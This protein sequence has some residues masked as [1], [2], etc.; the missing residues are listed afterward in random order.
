MP[1]DYS[2]PRRAPLSITQ[3]VIGF[4]I[5]LLM[6]LSMIGYG[7]LSEINA[8]SQK[9]SLNNQKAAQQELTETIT[10]ITTYL[11]HTARTASAWDELRQQ[12]NNSSYYNYWHGSRALNSGVLPS[13]LDAIELYDTNGKS[14][15]GPFNNNSSMPASINKNEMG[16]SLVKSAGHDYLFYFFPVWADEAREILLGYTGVK[17]DFIN[18]I[19]SLRKFRYL[20]LKTLHVDSR[21]DQPLLNQDIVANIKF[22]LAPNQATTEL[23]RIMHATLYRVGAI[24]TL[25]TFFAYLILTYVLARPLRQLSQHIDTIRNEQSN[26]LLIPPRGRFSV[27]ELEN[28]RLSLND[29]Q[30]RLEAMHLKLE[31][32]NDELWTLANHDPLTGIYNRRAFEDDCENLLKIAASNTVHTTFLLFDCDHFKAINDT[33]GHQVGDMVIQ[34]IAEAIH[35][36]LRA[37]DRLYRLGGDEFATLLYDT[38]IPHATKIAE[39]CTELINAYDFSNLG[40]MEPV[41]VSIGLAHASGLDREGLIILHKQA[42]LAMYHAKRPGQPNIAVFTDAMTNTNESLVSNLE[43]HAI[44]QAI[45]S[46]DMFQMHYQKVIR[47]PGNTIDYYE[48]LVRIRHGNNL[49]MPSGIFPVVEARRLEVEFDLAVI[50]RIRTDLKSEIV[51]KGTGVSINVSGPSIVNQEVLNKLLLFKPFLQDYKLVLEITETSLITQI[52]HASTN[53]N[54]LRK[55]GF[56]I[57]LDDFGSGYSSMRYLSNMPVDII[58]FDISMIHSLQDN[59]KQSL[60]VKNLARLLKNADYQLVAEGIETAELLE[61]VKQLEF[62]HAQG[63]FLGKPI[64]FSQ[65]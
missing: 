25:A 42:D 54:Q 24:I 65:T 3:Y 37:G 50:E 40:I 8:L 4:F 6:F 11:E 47:L 52:N 59:D 1:A 62:T 22:K 58:K 51:P 33:Y 28:V 35:A 18:R 41:R 21:E 36:A 12:F 26:H 23:E 38:D 10:Q 34:G 64:S 46:I 19:N 16:L 14:L 31:H 9:T 61:T 27:S 63:F 15:S 53:L 2:R 49:I 44:Y 43:T 57:A 56:V 29:Y 39:R 55:A 17:L 20:D 13:N 60:I 48:A 7:M 45:S 30:Q 32:K 5:I